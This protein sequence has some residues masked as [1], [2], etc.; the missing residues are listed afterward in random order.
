MQAKTSQLSE[1]L[2]RSDENGN[3]R[4]PRAIDEIKLLL[5]LGQPA[6]FQQEAQRLNMGGESAVNHLGLFG[7]EQAFG[8]LQAIP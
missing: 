6:L 5:H 3:I 2:L 8:G 7:D 4:A 1:K